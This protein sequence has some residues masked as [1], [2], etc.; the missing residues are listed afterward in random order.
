M[1]ADANKNGVADDLETGTVTFHIRSYVF[2]TITGIFGMGIVLSII[3]AVNPNWQ[4][5]AK[6]FAGNICDTVNSRLATCEQKRV[7][8]EIASE[9][10]KID[11]SSCREIGGEQ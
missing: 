8:Y 9:V 5:L 1:A 10:L 6:I 7:C 3:I 11:D 4:F 2:G